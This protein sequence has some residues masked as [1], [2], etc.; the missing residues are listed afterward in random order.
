MAAADFQAA[1]APAFAGMEGPPPAAATPE[2][3]VREFV[4]ATGEARPDP[5]AQMASDIYN[6]ETTALYRLRRH[7]LKGVGRPQPGWT[8]P[9]G[10]GPPS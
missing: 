1:I 6:S 10:L 4:E 5:G 3:A 7:F 2:D 9:P 8:P